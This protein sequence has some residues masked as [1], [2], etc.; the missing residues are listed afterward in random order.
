MT[1]VLAF[2]YF[3][4]FP[5]PPFP[6]ESSAANMLC[7]FQ[8]SKEHRAASATQPATYGRTSLSCT[9]YTVPWPAVLTYKQTQS[10]QAYRIR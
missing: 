2:F 9:C 4:S 5:F 10:S 8:V 7:S 1:F 6:F 3:L